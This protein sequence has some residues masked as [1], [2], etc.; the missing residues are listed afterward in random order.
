MKKILISLNLI[1]LAH[2]LTITPCYCQEDFF[3]DTHF[4]EAKNKVDILERQQE[5]KDNYGI[6]EKKKFFKK[7]PVQTRFNYDTN[8]EEI[9]PK[10]YYGELPDIKADFEYKK[11]FVQS[12]TETNAIPPMEADMSDE[13]LKKAPYNDDLFLDIIVK[14]ETTSQYVK[15]LQRT[16]I[17]LENLKKCIE[18][19]GSIQRF[20]GCVNLVDLYSKN[21]KK[22]YENQSESLKESYIDILNTAYHAKVL[23]NL[24]Y[25]SNYY[26]RFVPTQEGK[27]S[28]ANIK[29]KEQKLL[30]RVNKT[31]FLIQEES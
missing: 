14:K 21:L 30:N 31:L 9:I 23:G 26:A 3:I 2:F 22:K 6:V 1:L 5:K 4:V 18:E 7:E 8:K 20:N 12:S 15:D 10:G 17:A 28:E 24:M 29:N 25:D 13:N 19:D 27:Y 16:K 11:Q